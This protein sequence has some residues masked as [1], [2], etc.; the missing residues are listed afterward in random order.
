MCRNAAGAGGA[1]AAMVLVT[2]LSA[3][4]LVGTAAAAA[5]AVPPVPVVIMVESYCPCSGAWPYE[6]YEKILPQIGDIVTLDRFF[7]ASSSPLASQGCCNPTPN[8]TV[9]KTNVCFHGE[10]ECV[11]D[12]LQACAQAHYPAAWLAY[13]VCINGPFAGVDLL[14]CKH[15]FDVGTKKNQEVEQACAAR[16]NM[17]WAVLNRCWTGPEGVKLMEASAARSDSGP[18][19]AVYGYEGLPVV[20]I[21]GTRFSQFEQCEASSKKYQ[22]DFIKAVCAASTADPLPSACHQQ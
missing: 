4:S 12:R 20:W 16:H 22:A 19:K 13:T 3:S 1:G 17:S 9:P 5:T 7:D 15:Q 6:F 11:A 21:N 18:F 8:H 2:L 10:G 14:G